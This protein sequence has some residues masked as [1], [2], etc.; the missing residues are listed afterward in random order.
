MLVSHAMPLGDASPQGGISA[1]DELI[2][3]RDA[4]YD[5]TELLDFVHGLSRTCC[6]PA[7]LLYACIAITA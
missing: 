7:R 2:D 4:V 1:C 6:C 5:D 3:L